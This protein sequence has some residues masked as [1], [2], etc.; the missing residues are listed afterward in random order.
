MIEQLASSNWH[1]VAVIDGTLYI[2]KGGGAHDG[3]HEL[4]KPTSIAGLVDLIDI[5]RASILGHFQVLVAA[6]D[7]TGRR[8]LWQA[9]LTRL[10]KEGPTAWERVTLPSD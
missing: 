1:T 2:R 7:V 8:G 3:W 9:E 5:A 10:Q 6:V 4:A